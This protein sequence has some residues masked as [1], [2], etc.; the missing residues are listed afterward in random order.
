[1]EM[2]ENRMSRKIFGLNRDEVIGGW[3]KFHSDELHCLYS[4]PNVIIMIKSRRIKCA[5]HVP[6]M[7]EEF[8]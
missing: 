8:I 1:M 5:A 6:Y 4:S 7:T 2:P 3:R